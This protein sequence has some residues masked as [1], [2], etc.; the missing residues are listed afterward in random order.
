MTDRPPIEGSGSL[1]LDDLVAE[2]VETGD[3]GPLHVLLLE[4]DDD[5]AA[6]V[7]ALLDGV[8]PEVT[9]VRARTAEEAVDRLRTPAPGAPFDA[10][11]ADQQ[12]PDSSYWET[13]ERLADAAAGVPVVA[14][15][16]LGD[17]AVALDAVRKGAADYLVKS[18]LTPDLLRRT[19][20]HAVER[21][22][23]DTALR[24]TN[25]VLRHTLRHVR[26]MQ[27]QLVE[28]EKLAGLGRLLAGVAHEL[29]NPLGLAVTAAEGIQEEADA[30][31][32]ALQGQD[33]GSEARE[34]LAH[35]REA[36]TRVSENGRRADGVVRAMYEHARGVDGEFQ[37]V[38][39]PAVVQ[40]AIAQASSPSLRRTDVEVD[41]DG[42]VVRGVG[43]ALARMLANVVDN[44]AFAARRAARQ[45]DD[46]T[47]GRVRVTAAEHADAAGRPAV[48]LTVE[49]DGDGLVGEA[50]RVFEPFYSAWG[51]SRRV[52][53]GL[54]L[55]HAIAVSHGGTIE[56]GPSPLGGL[57]V[58]ITFPR[59]GHPGT[60]RPA[61]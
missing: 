3:A 7:E 12:L 11:L 58:R 13:V 37:P 23:R 1:P 5:H 6:L 57:S 39:L 9:L 43:S 48:V 2:V 15:T 44:A 29:R 19:L 20:R 24:E 49:D 30:L 42:S 27:A 31:A 38:A 53:L 18:E 35:V 50:G 56:L 4:D 8:T 41:V 17:D 21:S 52:G 34:A 32:S 45:R 47:P 61:V 51:S 33:L 59:E 54:T 60:D 46:G 36:A 22:R 26:Q 28:Q 14:L 55:A 25:E 16:S 10:V 40:A